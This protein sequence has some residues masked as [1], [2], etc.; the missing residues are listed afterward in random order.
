[1]DCKEGLRKIRSKFRS[2]E[3]VGPRWVADF[4]EIAEPGDRAIRIRDAYETVSGLLDLLGIESW[5][6][7]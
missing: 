6:G 4:L 2:V 7:P 3:D 5:D 1:M